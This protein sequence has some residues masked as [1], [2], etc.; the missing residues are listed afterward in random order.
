MGSMR[1]RT[2]WVLRYGEQGF[3]FTDEG[4]IAYRSGKERVTQACK[5]LSLSL[6]CPRKRNVTWSDPVNMLLRIPGKTT[7]GIY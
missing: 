5:I 2:L 1:L 3:H 7:D 6:G 4:S